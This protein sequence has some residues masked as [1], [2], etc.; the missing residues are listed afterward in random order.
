MPEKRIALLGSTGSIGCQTLEV[1]DITPDIKV[2]ILSGHA[3]WRLLSQQTKKYLPEAVIVT[4]S[5]AYHKVKEQLS[6]NI[7]ILPNWNQLEELLESVDVVVGAISGAAGIE[8]TLTALRLGK[9]VALANKETLVAAGDL[10][11][12]MLD[13]YHGKII[14]VDSEHSA[15]Y[16]C[17]ENRGEVKKII[18]TA[19]GGPFRKFSS[20][21][22]RSVTIEDALNHP[23]WSMGRKITIDS[24]TLM[25]KGLEVIEANRL[26]GVPY[27][28]IEVVVHPQSILHSAVQFVDGSIIGQ[29]GCADMRLPIQYA[30]NNT[31]RVGNNFDHL[32]MLAVGEMSFEKPR[33]DDFPSLALAYQAGKTGGSAPAVLNAAN[34]IAVENFLQKKIK[35][36]DIGYVVEEVLSHHISEKITNIEQ[37]KAIDAWARE[38][39]MDCIKKRDYSC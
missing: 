2:S 36:L 8:P 4:D 17:L 35:F 13:Q 12:L 11:D 24:A 9:T 3:N 19:S 38:A 15:I 16:Q 27:Q 22:L 32:D 10:V 18:L 7:K 20:E 30:L 5:T 31:Q 39:A 29:L 23:N 25:N 6:D 28:N 33:F 37:L 21:K 14:P 34:E 1:V 26:F